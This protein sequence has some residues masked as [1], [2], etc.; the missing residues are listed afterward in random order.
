MHEKY[1]VVAPK[2]ASTTSPLCRRCK[3]PLREGV[4]VALC[5][6]CGSEPSERGVMISW[7]P[8]GRQSDPFDD[9]SDSGGQD[10]DGGSA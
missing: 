7:M 1:G 6:A 8:E 5:V 4:N 3:R 10:D 9:S 2:P